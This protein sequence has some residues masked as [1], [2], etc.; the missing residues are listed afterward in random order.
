MRCSA[1]LAIIGCHSHSNLDYFPEI[2]RRE[3]NTAFHSCEKKK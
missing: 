2:L 3:G 1:K